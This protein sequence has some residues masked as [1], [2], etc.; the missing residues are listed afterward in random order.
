VARVPPDAIPRSS[1]DASPWFAEVGSPLDDTNPLVALTPQEAPDHL[2]YGRTPNTRPAVRGYIAI[3][4]A[5]P[6]GPWQQDAFVG[7]HVSPTRIRVATFPGGMAPDTPQRAN[8]VPAQAMSFGDLVT[9]TT[10]QQGADP[11]AGW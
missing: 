3:P 9:M 11:W 8:R 6:G 7:G 2:R 10:A 5:D 1:D 4:L